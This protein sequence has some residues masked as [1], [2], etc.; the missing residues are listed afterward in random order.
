MFSRLTFARDRGGLP[1]WSASILPPDAHCSRL[2]E[3][4]SGERLS[5]TV[6]DATIPCTMPKECHCERGNSIAN[7]AIMRLL[8][9]S[10]RRSPRLPQTN[11]TDYLYIQL[12]L[13]RQPFD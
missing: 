1:G 4:P 11:Y 7:R 10:L 2:S 5:P 13:H 9:S 3:W 8:S 6:V 12:L